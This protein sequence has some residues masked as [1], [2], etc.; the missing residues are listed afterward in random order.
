MRGISVYTPLIDKI[1]SAAVVGLVMYTGMPNRR[2]FLYLPIKTPMPVLSIKS[3]SLKSKITFI[4]ELP[5]EKKI[6]QHSS[7]MF[8]LYLVKVFN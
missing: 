7:L 4:R 3:S 6:S 8:A 2:N 1:L 5:F